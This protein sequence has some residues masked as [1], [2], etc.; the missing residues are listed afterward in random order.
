MYAVHYEDLRVR[1]KPVVVLGIN[2]VYSPDVEGCCYE[3]YIHTWELNRDHPLH[4]QDEG[5]DQDYFGRIKLVG[6][7]ELP[8]GDYQLSGGRVNAGAVLKLPARLAPVERPPFSVEEF[9]RLARMSGQNVVLCFAGVEGW[10]DTWEDEPSVPYMGHWLFA[11]PPPSASLPPAQGVEVA[12]EQAAAEKAAAEKAKTKGEQNKITKKG[13]QKGEQ[14]STSSD[15]K[16]AVVSSSVVS[17][18]SVTTTSLSELPATYLTAIVTYVHVRYNEDVCAPV[19]TTED[20]R[21]SFHLEQTYYSLVER[22]QG[23]MHNSDLVP[24][25]THAAMPLADFANTLAWEVCDIPA[26]TPDSTMS[27]LLAAFDENTLLAVQEDF[28][29]RVRV[30]TTQA[31]RPPARRVET[32]QAPDEDAVRQVFHQDD[33]FGC[34]VE[35]LCR[36]N[37]RCA[38]PLAM[39]CW[40]AFSA[41]YAELSH[42]TCL[43]SRPLGSGA[44]WTLPLPSTEDARFAQQWTAHDAEEQVMLQRRLRRGDYAVDVDTNFGPIPIEGETAQR[45]NRGRWFNDE[46]INAFV[47]LVQARVELVL[48]LQ[49]SLAHYLP[50]PSYFGEDLLHGPGWAKA[51][52]ARLLRRL[53]GTA[54]RPAKKIDGFIIP[55]NLNGNHWLAAQVKFE[56]VDPTEPD[57][58]R[59]L[60]VYGM[61]S[62]S[63][64]VHTV[65][66]TLYN[67]L[68]DGLRQ[69][70]ETHGDR[71]FLR[72]PIENDLG[73]DVHVVAAVNVVGRVHVVGR[74]VSPQ[75]RNNYDCGLFV[76]RWIEH[77]S[78][79]APCN[80]RAQHMESFRALTMLELWRG[81]LY[82]QPYT[83]GTD[84][85][86][87]YSC[88][89]TLELLRLA[90]STVASMQTLWTMHCDTVRQ[91][92]AASG[93]TLA[94]GESPGVDA[95]SSLGVLRA[96]LASI[97]VDLASMTDTRPTRPESQSA[98]AFAVVEHVAHCCI[99]EHCT[100]PAH[101][102]ALAATSGEHTL[103]PRAI[104]FDGFLFHQ[105][106]QREG[107]L[108]NKKLFLF[109]AVQDI[110][111][112]KAYWRGNNDV[113]LQLKGGCDARSE[114][115]CVMG[116]RL[117]DG[118]C[119]S[120]QAPIRFLDNLP[121]LREIHS[122][123]AM[124]Q[125]TWKLLS[126]ATGLRNEGG[127][128][129][130]TAR[131]GAFVGDYTSMDG[132]NFT[133]SADR[134]AVG[135][136]WVTLKQ[137]VTGCANG[138]G[139]LLGEDGVVAAAKLN[140]LFKELDTE[141]A[142]AGV[143][144][145][146]R[147]SVFVHII[148]VT[149]DGLHMDALEHRDQMKGR[150]TALSIGVPLGDL[151]TECAQLHF[152]GVHKMVTFSSTEPDTTAKS[153]PPPA[154]NTAGKRRMVPDGTGGADGAVDRRWS[155]P[156]NDLRRLSSVVST[157]SSSGTGD[158]KKRTRHP[159][160]K[161]APLTKD[162]V[163]D[164]GKRRQRLQQE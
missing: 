25:A 115:N 155:K 66:V 113:A 10:R 108:H 8:G 53:R 23:A 156:R 81:Q 40:G 138:K 90:K 94:A 78:I 101:D 69:E 141:L 148:D 58:P 85:D 137:F 15:N 145:S 39:T 67:V 68:K 157:P 19:Y 118:P 98:A 70:W 80:Y 105:A 1:G 16:S 33:M 93:V 163:D 146:T 103:V 77:A 109:A 125:L 95:M 52:R 44:C 12:A 32:M 88:F 71:S 65:Y 97:T 57:G 79:G 130:S 35:A 49:P 149:F 134:S 3:L 128:K 112:Y 36:G 82:R 64:S 27:D 72:G 38:V 107:S 140:C 139:E 147:G 24:A 76:M 45:L 74:D 54:V 144:S 150:S 120:A 11:T 4:E 62:L 152:P 83:G 6:D 123:V 21:V 129:D 42:A 160:A 162:D 75:Q 89:P 96:L 17:S 114:F 143:K 7:Y 100:L 142:S 106:Q 61:D 56:A 131:L 41:V 26:V 22:L 28:G 119:S 87:C 43:A 159:W 122:D 158:S 9:Q 111:R 133:L 63:T 154:G 127:P 117:S 5:E 92:Y 84:T 102:E 47:G 18:N 37:F 121:T 161:K 126:T 13:K 34:I 136:D 116:T 2:M 60:H 104:A 55:I 29:F 46:I 99:S 86:S 20:Y 153:M 14:N 30:R 59:E 48:P 151:R 51:Q 110:G 50:M 124:L 31:P 135:V 73:P 132:K 164:V 91:R